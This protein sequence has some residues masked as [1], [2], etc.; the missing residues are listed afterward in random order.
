[1]LTFVYQ[2]TRAKRQEEE[3]EST[4]NQLPTVQKD[5]SSYQSQ[6]ESYRKRAQEAETALAEAKAEVEKQRLALKEKAEK[7]DTERRPWLEDLPNS[8]LR[9]NSRPE[10]PL[11]SPPQRTFSSEFLGLQGFP[12]KFRKPSAPSSNG[13]LGPGERPSSL[14]RPSA[15]PPT[16]P[17]TI[18]TSSGQSGNSQQ[19]L[20]GLEALASPSTYPLDRDD[21]TDNGETPASPQNVLQDMVSVSTVG[22]GP[23]VQ[24]VE[25]MSAAIRRLESE[26]V[27][28]K[29]EL[30]RISSQ[31]DEAR[32]EIVTLMKDTE[33]GKAAASR[34]ESLEQEVAEINER[35]QTTLEMLGEKSELVEELRADVE[36]VKAMYRDLVERTIK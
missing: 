2:A 20:S 25:R 15:Q 5:L 35:Y 17:S 34:V 3:L 10:S 27:A 21:I 18:P 11:L 36:D 6:L 28:A 31:R 14:R 29:E 26:K 8:S 24:L 32:A 30:A 12:A 22:A 9:T 33:A 7:A 19:H 23:S 13:D 16:R 4:R 1:M